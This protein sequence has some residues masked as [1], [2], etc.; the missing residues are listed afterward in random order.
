MDTVRLILDRIVHDI[1]VVP[2]C[3]P[4]DLRERERGQRD[5]DCRIDDTSWRAVRDILSSS[6]KSAFPVDGDKKQQR[7]EKGSEDEIQ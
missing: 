1:P 4:V 7:V 5:P 3:W 2:N 6:T